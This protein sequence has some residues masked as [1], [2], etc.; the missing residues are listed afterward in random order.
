M[1]HN[2]TRVL[3]SNKNLKL[4]I[5]SPKIIFH[6][7]SESIWAA[8]TDKPK[9]SHHINLLLFHIGLEICQTDICIYSSALIYSES[10]KRGLKWVVA[11]VIGCFWNPPPPQRL[12][13]GKAESEMLALPTYDMGSD[14]ERGSCVSSIS[15]CFSS[16]VT[17]YTWRTALAQLAFTFN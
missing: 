13:K 17:N 15:R 16:S 11:N 10:S 12:N 5:M 8:G 4:P 6:I 1:F 7:I 14:S 2:W 9:D 3:K